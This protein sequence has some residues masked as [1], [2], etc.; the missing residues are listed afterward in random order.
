MILLPFHCNRFFVSRQNALFPL[1]RNPFEQ[2]NL[3]ICPLYRTDQI[4]PGIP[5]PGQCGSAQAPAD[6]PQ[7]FAG[8]S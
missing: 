7:F 2:E 5:F 6:R 1:N 3:R 8:V 4:T